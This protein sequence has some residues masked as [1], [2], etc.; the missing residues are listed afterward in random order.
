M[1]TD[2]FM[3]EKLGNNCLEWCL[4]DSKCDLVRNVYE[5]SVSNSI[6][7]HSITGEQT[8]IKIS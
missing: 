4:W 7:E 3:V 1:R 2:R 8:N 5:R 6:L